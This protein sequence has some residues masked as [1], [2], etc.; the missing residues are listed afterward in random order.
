MPSVQ[1]GSQDL[2]RGYPS[3]AYAFLVV[4]RLYHALY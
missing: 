1:G 3:T 4:F 2:L